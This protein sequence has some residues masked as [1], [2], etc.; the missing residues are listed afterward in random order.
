MIA[1]S[2]VSGKVTGEGEGLPGA[3]IRVQGTLVGTVT[4]IDGNF[5]ISV[6]SDAI[7]EISSVGFT[8]QVVPVNGQTRIDITLNIDV[9]QLEEV[10]VIGYG[11]Q[12]KSHLT[13]AISKVTNKKLDQIALSRADEAL[14]GQVA[15]VTVAQTGEDGVGSDPTLRVRGVGSITAGAGPLL[16]IDG[17]A[18]SSDFF[19]SVDMNDVESFEVLKDA[20]SA[21]IFGSRGGNGVIMITTKQGV[22]GR[23]KFTYST[24][25]GFQDV[26]NNPDYNMSV[27]EHANREM[28]YNEAMGNTPLLS[29]RTRYK[30]L[31]GDQNWQDVI[32]D[33]G[34]IT[35][36]SLSVRGG[37]AKTKFSTSLSYLHDEGVLLTDDFKK[38]NLKAKIDHKVSDK[39][40]F[41]ITVNP[42]YTNRRRFDGSTH[43]I[44]RQE[45]WLPVYLDANTIQYVDRVAYPDAQIGDYAVQTMFN[46]YDLNGDGGEV[47]ISGTSNTN[48]AA[49]VLEKEYRDFK[50][51]VFGKFYANYK[52]NDDFSV[53]TS[54]GGDMQDTERTRWQ[55]SEAD[56][57]GSSRSFS[58]FQNSKDVHTVMD[59]FVNYDR[60]FGNHSISATA[61]VARETF[62]NEYSDVTGSGFEFDYI[63]TLNG[64]TVISGADGYNREKTLLSFISR[65]N[66]AFSDKYLASVSL[67]RDGSSVFGDNKKYGMFP[68]VSIGWRVTEEDFFNSNI[69]NDL[70]IRVSYGV[71][72]NDNINS[73]YGNILDWYAYSALLEAESAITEGAVSAAFNPIN[74]ANPDLQWERSF[75]FN[76]AIDFGLFEG[77]ISGSVDYYKRTSEKLLLEIPVS[78]VT[79]FN[80]ALVNIGEVVNKGIEIELRTNNMRTNNFS[81]TTTFLAANNN[82]ELTNFADA[83]GQ[84][85][86]VDSKR[87]GEWINL[88]GNPISS[89]YGFVVDKEIP[90]EYINDPFSTVGGKAQHVYVKDLNGDGLI[91]GDDRTILGSP[92]PKLTWSVTNE[93]RYKSFD[94]SFMYQGRHGVSVRNIADEYMYN[95]FESTSSQQFNPATTPDQGFLKR[96]VLT[97]SIIQDGSYVALRNINIGYTLSNA[98]LEKVRLYNARVFVSG[99]NLLY[100]K[101]SDY[102]GFNPE[103]IRDEG[104]LAYG[105]NRGGSPIARKITI[106]VS[107]DF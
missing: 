84:I 67:R 2:T 7:L 19:G 62:R 55:G 25:T 8:T 103:T 35:S 82:N 73:D 18:V 72:G 83:S 75:E 15:G 97:N 77:R 42:S 41:G 86:S 13:G 36:H 39:F 37:S 98:A 9:S 21:A 101:S 30:Q 58:Y 50:F 28:A 63:E 44:L 74:I 85:L 79:G 76:P 1:Q 43:D 29:D 100:I 70:K 51:K 87:P 4:D 32:F 57:R 54:I 69:V 81:W 89:F 33:G 10:V 40:S 99:Q 38:Y 27:A 107:V 31:I 52:I 48:P 46:N 90:L 5:S 11:T 94:M 92:Y 16:V 17:V 26:K 61:G 47:D 80:E 6:A 106:G 65:V 56:R 64:A 66:Y 93:F 20:A 12:K 23:T 45:A 3:T 91:D 34:V 96:K 104:P 59:G 49:K 105:Y 24:F 60:D 14:I 78:G 68:A 102:S 53:S 95:F 71:T 88:V 22:E